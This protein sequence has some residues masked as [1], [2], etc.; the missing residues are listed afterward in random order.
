MVIYRP[1]DARE[2]EFVELERCFLVVGDQ[3]A[4]QAVNLRGSCDGKNVMREFSLSTDLI[5]KHCHST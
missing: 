5:F 2:Q 1:G 3:L 4:Y